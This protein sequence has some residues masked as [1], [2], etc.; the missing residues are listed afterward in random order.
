MAVRKYGS[1]VLGGR[2]ALLAH[3]PPRLL[4]EPS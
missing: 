1:E 4:N 2:S 3:L